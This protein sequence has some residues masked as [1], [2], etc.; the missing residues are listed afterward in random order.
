MD[1]AHALASE[2]K[3]GC[4]TGGLTMLTSSLGLLTTASKSADGTYA[5]NSATVR[6]TSHIPCHHPTCQPVVVLLSCWRG[7][8]SLLSRLSS[9]FPSI[10][11]LV[12]DQGIGF[13]TWNVHF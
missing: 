2:R 11:R 3:V 8:H 13:C 4:A 9:D 5:Y 12:G 1:H 6:Y 10:V 7:D